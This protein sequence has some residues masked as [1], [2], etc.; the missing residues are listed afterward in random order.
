SNI[1]LELLLEVMP[2]GK[3]AKGSLLAVLKELVAR[4]TLAKA[5]KTVL[6]KR[7]IELNSTRDAEGFGQTAQRDFVPGKEHRAENI[8][9]G[10]VTDR[11]G[12]PRVDDEKKANDLLLTEQAGGVKPPYW[13]TQRAAWKE[14]TIVTDKVLEQPRTMTMVIDQRQ[15]DA[16]RNSEK[17]GSNPASSL[18]GWA[19]DFPV[20]SIA[21]VRNKL[22]IS[23]EFKDGNLYKVE[24][25]IRP[26]VGVREG[27]AGD[28]WDATQKI[29]LPGGANQVNFMDK[30]PRENPEFYNV[31]V[32]SL[33]LLK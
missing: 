28:M 22:A 5:E 24:F 6:E 11:D 7:L 2:A 9:A 10:Q 20:N 17:T 3:M 32:G 23:S 19:T 16:M 26:G 33:R 4:D 30:T 12:L 13:G 29:R 15:Y 8:N 21:D 1:D 25:T 31:D 27:T 18:G 14:G